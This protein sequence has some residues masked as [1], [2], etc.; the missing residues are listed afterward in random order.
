[1][2]FFL[3]LD[4]QS[5]G[6]DIFE[7]VLDYFFIFDIFLNFNVAYKDSTGVLITDWKM[8]AMNYL[9]GFFWID[10]LTSIPISQIF[11][12]SDSAVGSFNKLFRLFRLPKI[13]SK[14]KLNKEFSLG[15]LLRYLK[16]GNMWRYKIKSKEALLSSLFLGF[17]TFLILHLGACI[18]IFIGI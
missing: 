13:Y 14:L 12:S 11:R 6:L 1:M 18:F 17:V 10:L 15:N 7:M 4:S 5:L 2:P 16:L 3:F 8:I 9:K